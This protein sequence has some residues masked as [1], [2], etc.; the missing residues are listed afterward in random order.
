MCKDSGE[1]ELAA[2]AVHASRPP[3]ACCGL[4]WPDSR[5]PQSWHSKGREDSPVAAAPARVSDVGLSCLP[6]PH[7]C[8]RSQALRSVQHSEGLRGDIVYAFNSRILSSSCLPP[9][10]LLLPITLFPLKLDL[11]LCCSRERE[12]TTEKQTFGF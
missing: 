3:E 2:S 9:N 4:W 8:P 1:A 5:S 12:A 6:Q 7:T 11:G 10:L